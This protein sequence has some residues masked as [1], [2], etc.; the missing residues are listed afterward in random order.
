MCVGRER[1]RRRRA[2]L[3]PAAASRARFGPTRRWPPSPTSRKRRCEC[4]VG[5]AGA[6]SAGGRAGAAAPPQSFLQ[7]VHPT[8][9]RATAGYVFN[10][11]MLRVKSAEKSLDFYTRVLGFRL[12]GRIEFP[13]RQF[14]LL[15][16]HMGTAPMAAAEDDR[17]EA[18]FGQPGVLELT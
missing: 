14:D 13:D 4:R 11:T 16:L 2:R 18:L 7:G 1:E 6:H 3:T 9:D 12:A 10:H 5:A 15:F 17:L 8:R